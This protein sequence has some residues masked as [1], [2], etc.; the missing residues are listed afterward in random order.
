MFVIFVPHVWEVF[1]LPCD[2]STR[3]RFLYQ[4]PKSMLRVYV[5]QLEGQGGLA[6]VGGVPERGSWFR[7]HDISFT[8]C[9]IQNSSRQT[10]HSISAYV[11]DEEIY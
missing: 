9:V 11:N 1:I 5:P 7:G 4:C 8:W 6:G 3:A 10:R 2:W